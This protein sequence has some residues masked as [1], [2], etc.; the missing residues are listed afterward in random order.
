M[1]AVD[2]ANIV[3]PLAWP[4]TSLLIAAL[5]YRPVCAVLERL[6]ETVTFK[7]IKVKVL[8]VE[9]ELTPEYARTVLHELLDDITATSNQL[10]PEEVALFDSILVAAG[11]KSVAELIPGFERESPEHAQ[12]RNLRDQKLVLPKEKRSWKATSHPVVTPY[13]HL[14][15]SLRT[16][17]A[18]R[19][20][21]FKQN[22]A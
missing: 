5:F 3:T 11:K 14:V 12:L 13:G 15:A 10:T 22:G 7:T 6:A 17:N 20:R 9:A 1:L 2:F 21:S 16:T 8:G 4:V 18:E 19:A